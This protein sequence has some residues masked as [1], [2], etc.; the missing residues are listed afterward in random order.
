MRKLL[1]IAATLAVAFTLSMPV[2]AG[3]DANSGTTTT[4][5]HSKHHKRHHH[6]HKNKKK[7]QNGTN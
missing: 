3:Q 4:S 5:H 6:A 7:D 2:F 1:A